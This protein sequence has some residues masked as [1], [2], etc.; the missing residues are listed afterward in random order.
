MRGWFMAA[1]G[2]LLLCAAA[3]AGPMSVQ[4]QHGVLKSAPSFLAKNV[5]SVSYGDRVN[6]LLKE[7]DWVKVETVSAR[8]WLHATA[9]TE[10]V[11]VLQN[12]SRAAAT[13]VSSSEIVL[14]G[15]GFNAQVESKYR[16][17][18]PN[19]R[20]DRVDAMERYAIQ[21]EAEREF[22]R[23]GLLKL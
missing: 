11:I 15:K 1:A 22:A 5:A 10:R 14:A 23:D 9:V 12:G 20:F 19:M 17:D 18:N 7:G 13:G 4:I 3:S 6:A 8:G 16:Q 2:L 21:P